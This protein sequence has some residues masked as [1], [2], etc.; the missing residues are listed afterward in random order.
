MENGMQET[1][2]VSRKEM[3]NFF[4]GSI[5]KIKKFDTEMSDWTSFSFPSDLAMKITYN[6]SKFIMKMIFNI[7]KF[8]FGFYLMIYIFYIAVPDNGN[9][10]S[11]FKKNL[12]LPLN[13]IQKMNY[14]VQENKYLELLENLR[15]A[16][17][18]LKIDYNIQDF[19]KL[20]FLSQMEEMR[21]IKVLSSEKGMIESKCSSKKETKISETVRCKLK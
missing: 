10:S 3:K 15:K 20:G 18:N 11:N 17:N 13:Y 2:T 9:F 16:N 6:I 21:K 5:K 14:S 19:S 4:K 1:K 7:S 12:T 8:V